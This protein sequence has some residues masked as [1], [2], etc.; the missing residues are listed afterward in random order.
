MKNCNARWSNETGEALDRIL[1]WVTK[2]LRRL[3]KMKKMVD[4]TTKG[5]LYKNAFLI[6]VIAESM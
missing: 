4:E 2:V 5:L 1:G 3:F 6:E